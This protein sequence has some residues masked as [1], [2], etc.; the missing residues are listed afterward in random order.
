MFLCMYDAYL[1]LAD[2]NH[3]KETY[4][5]RDLLPTHS[6]AYILNNTP[7]H[8]AYPPPLFFQPSLL[9]CMYLSIAG[10]WRS[11]CWP[12]WPIFHCLL[13]SACHIWLSTTTSIFSPALN[14]I[15]FH[16]TRAGL[17][18]A[19]AMTMASRGYNHTAVAVTALATKYKKVQTTMSV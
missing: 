9:F 11:C 7:F 8:Y 16:Q 2:W 14:L 13:L 10:A 17:R 18:L 3:K 19:V 15:R 12:F 1:C 5:L 6:T 4:L